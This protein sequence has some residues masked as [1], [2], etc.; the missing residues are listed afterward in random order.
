M[1][2]RKKLGKEEQAGIDGGGEGG[3]SRWLL[4]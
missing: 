3:Q 4:A 2:P 1:G